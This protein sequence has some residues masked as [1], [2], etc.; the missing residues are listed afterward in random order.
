MVYDVTTNTVST[1]QILSTGYDGSVVAFLTPNTVWYRFQIYDPAGVFKLYT[2]P[3]EITTSTK[4]FYI[5]TIT[6]YFALFEQQGQIQCSIGFSNGTSPY[7]N[8]T[9]ADP[10]GQTN[11][12]CFYVHKRT[13]ANDVI[14][15]TTCVT[16][17]SGTIVTYVPYTP[18][19]TDT[20]AAEGYITT[21][22]NTFTCGTPYEY[23]F[24]RDWQMFGMFGLFLSFLILLALVMIGVWNPVA[25]VFL[26]MVGLI[27]VDVLGFWHISSPVLIVIEI[28]LGVA[29]FRLQQK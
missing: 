6:P 1:S 25:S 13:L 16:S 8:Y 5:S 29:L 18:N 11:T 3:Q 14:T 10:T 15:N 2:T 17:T 9:W 12:A 28:A 23:T 20:F 22:G 26:L 4:T 7:F 21:Q 27:I 24:S 19:G